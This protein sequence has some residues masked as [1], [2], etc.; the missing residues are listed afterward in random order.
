MN[1]FKAYID[2]I[3][4]VLDLDYGKERVFYDED[5]TWYDRHSSNYVDFDYICAEVKE[6]SQDFYDRL[7]EYIEKGGDA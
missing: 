5:G 3:K 6:I 1:E 7:E 2:A 4:F